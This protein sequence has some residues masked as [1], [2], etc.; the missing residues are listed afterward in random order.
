MRWFLIGFLFAVQDVA[1]QRRAIFIRFCLL[2]VQGLPNV[3]K[4]AN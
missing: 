4:L 2:S 1:K 3:C